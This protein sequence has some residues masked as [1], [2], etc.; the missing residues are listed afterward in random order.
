MF[1]T[2]LIY[3]L[4]TLDGNRGTMNPVIEKIY[5]MEAKKHQNLTEVQKYEL[6]NSIMTRLVN[7]VA[8]NYSVIRVKQKLSFSAFMKKNTWIEL[9][10]SQILRTHYTLT[11]TGQIPSLNRHD[12]EKNIVNRLKEDDMKSLFEELIKLNCENSN[13]IMNRHISKIKNEL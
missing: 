12:L 1:I 2:L 7:G 4:K 3:K 11:S 6:R 5:R 9:W 10:L 13:S 8:K